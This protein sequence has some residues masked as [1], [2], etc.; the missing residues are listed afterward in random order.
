MIRGETASSRNPDFLLGV[1]ERYSDCTADNDCND[2]YT[3]AKDSPHVSN[4]TNSFTARGCG[5]YVRNTNFGYINEHVLASVT[6]CVCAFVCGF[7][8]VCTCVYL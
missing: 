3:S 7:K 4:A 2:S 6:I 5:N 8:M 1:Y